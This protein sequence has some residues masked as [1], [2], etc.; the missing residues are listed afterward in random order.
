[1]G[2]RRGGGLLSGR[3]P[4]VFLDRD[5]V[6]ND[7][8]VRAG[9]SGRAESPLDPADVRLALGAV[10]GVRALRGAGWLLVGASN[11]PGAAKGETTREA[12][13]AVHARV[14]ELLAARGAALDGWEYC[15]HHP[16]AVDAALRACDCRK[17]A[18]GLLLRAAGAHG[19]DLARSWLVGDT[20]AD[21]GAARAAGV[22]FALVEHP[23]SAHRR[24][25]DEVAA[26]RGPDLATVA[27]SI[28]RPS[29]P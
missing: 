25:L 18:A 3:A 23:G 2:R 16:D 14:V 24:A 15:L 9:T 5:G 7:P 21:A 12:L 28:G 27:A 6:L 20:A 26:A 13:C 1:M 11:Q 8:V 17:P 22:A 19:I 4:A 10:A 29:L